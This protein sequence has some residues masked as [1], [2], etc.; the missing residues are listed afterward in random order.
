MKPHIPRRPHSSA[1]HARATRPGTGRLLMTLTLALQMV[2]VLTGCDAGNQDDTD[3]LG[4]EPYYR[5]LPVKIFSGTERICSEI[6]SGGITFKRRPD[7]FRLFLSATL[8]DCPR[9]EQ[10]LNTDTPSISGTWSL[11]G[12]EVLFRGVTVTRPVGLDGPLAWPDM[13][14]RLSVSGKALSISVPVSNDLTVFPFFS[15][16]PTESVL[17]LLFW[18]LEMFELPPPCSWLCFGE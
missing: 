13:S 9:S 7:T 3:N 2:P 12:E 8:T 4:P 1:A 18:T 17:E 16:E 15:V 10:G 6:Q 14:G 11:S 5:A